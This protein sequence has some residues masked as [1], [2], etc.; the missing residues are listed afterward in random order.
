M[1]DAPR[2]TAETI[3]EAAMAEFTGYD[4]G[5][6][7]WVDLMCPDLEQAKHF[8]EPVF[9]WEYTDT[10][11]EYGNYTMAT[12]NGK[13]IAGLAPS[14][15][16]QP[17]P[18]AWVTYL[19]ADDADAVAGRVVKAD[20]NV[21][22]GP[23]DVPGAGRMALALDSTGA[24]FGIW[25]GRE[26]RGAQLANEPG[27]FTWNENLN[28]DPG[29]ARAFYER[30]FG[31]TYERLPDWPGE[32]HTFKV[33]DQVRGGVG[34]KPAQIPPGTPNFWNTYF[35]VADTDETVAAATRAGGSVGL[36][37]MDTPVGRMAVLMDPAG[38]QFSII[39][40]PK[41]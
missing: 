4:E 34:A 18:P 20:G 40:V 25:Q 30:V 29:K 10:G 27:S 23:M 3:R 35:S 17:A 22:M 33:K 7:C 32:Y 5:T 13:V 11:P 38:A 16:G 36:E 15:P 19:W 39:S 31:Y 12:K 28:D 24:A 1:A 2:T 9:G 26:H 37:P 8:Y 21:F 6:P 14:Q 41:G